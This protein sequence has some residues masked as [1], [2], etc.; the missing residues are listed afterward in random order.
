MADTRV[1]Q[2]TEI[3]LP[4]GG[5]DDVVVEL[6]PQKPAAHTVHQT[7]GRSFDK[8]QYT[9]RERFIHFLKEGYFGSENPFDDPI[10]EALVQ[11]MGPDMFKFEN[12]K[13]AYPLNVGN[14]YL[15]ADLIVP[16]EV[17]FGVFTTGLA[18]VLGQGDSARGEQ[19]VRYLLTTD[20]GSLFGLND[21]TKSVNL[22]KGSPVFE[23]FPE[24]NKLGKLK[25]T[26]FVGKDPHLLLLALDPRHRHFL[27]LCFDYALNDA[28]LPSFTNNQ[29][30]YDR[31]M[32]VDRRYFSPAN[33]LALVKGSLLP[34]TVAT[35]VG[36]RYDVRNLKEYVDTARQ[37]EA[38]LVSA[39]KT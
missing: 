26:K 9:L 4:E 28:K 24:L 35:E 16:D 14:R 11:G 27:S 3:K 34:L 2:G 23:Y 25:G 13:F 8:E 37:L 31:S 20:I 12:L 36:M 33:V 32:P 7:S 30:Q 15:S 6:P 17:P 19:R 18:A 21:S 1:D 5:L 39:P 29:N 10:L 38:Q 22:A